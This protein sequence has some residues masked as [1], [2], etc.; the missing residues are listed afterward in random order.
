MSNSRTTPVTSMNVSAEGKGWRVGRT[1]TSYMYIQCIYTYM[2]MYYIITTSQNAQ[3]KIA[4]RDFTRRL[5]YKKI[6][7]MQVC[8]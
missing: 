2:Y 5:T 1:H 7:W 3:V 8:A 4:R 6:A